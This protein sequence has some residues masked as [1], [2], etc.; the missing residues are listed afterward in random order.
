M[1]K[2]FACILFMILFFSFQVT[3][4]DATPI[5]IT[6]TDAPF[7]PIIKDR[8]SNYLQEVSIA[9][10]DYAESLKGDIS[11]ASIGGQW[12]GKNIAKIS[13]L[14]LYLDDTLLIDF[15]QYLGGLSKSEKKIL[16]TSLKHGELIQFNISID[17]D[18]LADLE[19]GQAHLYLA[20][21]PKFFSELHLED[22]TL[23][24][25]DP[26]PDDS[27]GP[28]P[29]PESGTLLFLGCGLIG[30]VGF[31]RRKCKK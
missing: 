19:D 3:F 14:A 17:Q 29:V 7:I 26:I 15:D 11:S 18:G 25:V 28:L 10:F 1:K 5:I 9:D 16:K 6:V 12:G 30:L 4:G 24:M 21:K 22:I 8:T 23:T 31:A 20:G 27:P 13:K 2:I